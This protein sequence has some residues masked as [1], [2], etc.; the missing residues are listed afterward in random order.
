MD[1]LMNVSLEVIRDRGHW[2]EMKN[3]RRYKK[4]GRYLKRLALVQTERVDSVEAKLE[5]IKRALTNLVRST[6]LK[7]ASQRG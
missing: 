4:Q 2:S 5:N 6:P 1:G 7:G 3:V